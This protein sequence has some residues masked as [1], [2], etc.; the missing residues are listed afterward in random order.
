MKI[1]KISLLVLFVLTLVSCSN[2]DKNQL[3]DFPLAIVSNAF[4]LGTDHIQGQTPIDIVT[5]STVKMTSIDPVIHYSSVVLSNVQN[6]VENLKINLSDVDKAAN[7]ITIRG[8]KYELQ[9]FHFHH[10]SEHSI[11]GTYGEMEIHFV[12]KSASGAYAV[13]GVI[14]K[15]GATN[16]SLQTLIDDSPSAEG[17]NEYV[18]SF[19]LSSILPLE[20][21]KY[22]SYSGS[23][24]TP[25]MDLTPN[26]GP[27]TWFVFKNNI[28]LTAAQL[29]EYK[30][31][32]VEENFRVIQP[33]NNR[34]V[35]ENN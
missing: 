24:T 33:L 29:E 23:L 14:V 32:Y 7:Y 6:T 18:D 1:K 4:P 13:L 16:S 30:V 28:T 22:Y 31:K 21:N 17:I 20:T 2:G 10:H 25:N 3:V 15:D 26:Q 11:N 5:S 35:Y 19:N 34:K 9:Q 27:L 12:N 8:F